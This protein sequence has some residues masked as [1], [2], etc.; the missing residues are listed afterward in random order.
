VYCHPPAKIPI[1]TFGNWRYNIISELPSPEPKY[2][3]L[4]GM[5]RCSTTQNDRKCAASARFQDVSVCPLA[6]AQS[7]NFGPKVFSI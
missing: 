2:L 5:D 7:L 4:R 6:A 1:F 3:E